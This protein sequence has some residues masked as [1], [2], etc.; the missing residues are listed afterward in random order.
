MGAVKSE[1][2]ILASKPASL[3]V[4]YRYLYVSSNLNNAFITIEVEIDIR[5]DHR[6]RTPWDSTSFI[7]NLDCYILTSFHDDNLDGRELIFI[8]DSEALNDSS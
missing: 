6:N 7:T 5:P 3:I 4:V 8:I 1:L 2:S